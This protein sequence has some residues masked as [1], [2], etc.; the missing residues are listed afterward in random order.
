M[1]VVEVVLG[2]IVVL[3]VA[4]ALAAFGDGLPAAPPDTNDPLLP[5]DRLLTSTD[6]ASVRFRTAAYGY[7]MEDV[8]A[9]MAAV[10]AALWA[11]EQH[12]VASSAE[13]GEAAE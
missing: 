7:R 5:G 9:T 3:V 8:D 1:F 12:A 10:H 6:L 4:V 2:V 11:R 13:T